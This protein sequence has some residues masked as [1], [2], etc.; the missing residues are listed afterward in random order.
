MMMMKNMPRVTLTARSDRNE[1]L[2][3]NNYNYLFILV[4]SVNK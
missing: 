2:F 4:I 1:G 3:K